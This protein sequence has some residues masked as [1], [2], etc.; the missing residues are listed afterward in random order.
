VLLARQN[1]TQTAVQ[2][3]LVAAC[4]ALGLVALAAA[5]PVFSGYL[6]VMATGFFLIERDAP[7]ARRLR[8]GFDGLWT[9]AQ[10]WLFVLLGASIQPA[11]LGDTVVVGLLILALGTLV[12]RGLGWY[13]ATLGSNWTWRERLFLLPGNSAKATVQAAIG[14]IPLAAGIAG[15]ETILAIAALSILVTA[16]LG[17][18]AIPTFAPR[19]LERGEVDP[20]RVSVAQRV[21]LLAAVDTSPLAAVVLAKVAELARRSDGE[22][23]VLHVVQRQDSAAEATLRALGQRQLA[24]IRHRLVLKPGVVP[25]VIVATALDLGATEIVVGRRGDRPLETMLLGSVS[26][27]VLETSPLP[28][29]T[30]GV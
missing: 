27:T 9:V 25:E 24:D 8:G 11:V 1:W 2:D 28:V 21:L 12:G 20:T 10:I 15:G 5:V 7:L 19:L 23:I 22:V 13:L 4:L 14:A 29:L 3:A 17:A 26:R 16:P 18:W 6:A 30:V